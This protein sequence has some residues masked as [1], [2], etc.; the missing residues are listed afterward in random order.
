MQLVA[1]TKFS[2]RDKDFHKNSPGHTK[3]F[4]AVL[5]RRNVLL[6][7]VTQPVQSHA[8]WSVTTTCCCNLSHSVF[9]PLQQRANVNMYHVTR[10]SF[11]WLLFIISVQKNW[12]QKSV[13]SHEFHVK[14]LVCTAFI[15]SFLILKNCQLKFAVCC[16]PQTWIKIALLS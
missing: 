9:L 2:C 3:W 10:F 8:E 5:C 7:L 4:I 13:L 6:Q 1:A 16:V 12:L 14:E 11:Y 15:H